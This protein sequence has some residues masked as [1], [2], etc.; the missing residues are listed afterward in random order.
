MIHLQRCAEPAIL[1]HE[2]QNWTMALLAATTDEQ[3]T[4]IESKYRHRSIKNA[5][6]TMFHG[7][8]AYCESKIIHVD[9]GHIEHFRPKGIPKFRALAFD[10]NNLFLACAV[11]NGREYKGT[12]FP[13]KNEG[14]PAVNPCDDLPEKHLLFFFDT[15]SR[16][17]T[18]IY[19]TQ[20][21]KVSVD[22][23]GLNRPELRAHRSKQ[24]EK[25]IVLSRLAPTDLEA[26]RLFEQSQSDEEEYAAFSRAIPR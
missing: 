4:K 12:R 21:G 3:R 5:L 25:L 9:Y 13:E 26:R 18:V 1:V 24:I 20:R 8:C 6:V 16:I 7:K 2:K 19:L 15:D 17:A 22:L 14:G 11:C 23:F 10:W